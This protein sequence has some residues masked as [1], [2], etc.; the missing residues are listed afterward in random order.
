MKWITNTWKTALSAGMPKNADR[1]ARLPPLSWFSTYSGL[2]TGW[3]C[4]SPAGPQVELGQ[5]MDLVLPLWLRVMSHR[6][7]RSA[8]CLHL[9]HIVPLQLMQVSETIHVISSTEYVSILCFCFIRKYVWRICTYCNTIHTYRTRT[10]VRI[11]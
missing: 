5:A 4:I 7:L 1:R 6:S 3:S 10:Y 9:S 2:P 11:V 8:A